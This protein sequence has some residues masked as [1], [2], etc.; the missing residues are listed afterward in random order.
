MIKKVLI[1]L[2]LVFIISCNST[3]VDYDNTTIKVGT[4][5]LE[6][7]GDGIDDRKQRSDY[8]YK[9]I[10]D[11]VKE[12]GADIIGLQEIENATALDKLIKHLPGFKYIVGETGYVQNPAVIFRDS[13]SVK[14]VENYQPLAVKPQ[15]TRAGL[16]V[17]VKKGN[18]DF[19]MMVVH[20]KSTSRYD[21]TEELRKESFE[22][23]RM[24]ALVVK[25]W[26][27][28]I[29]TKTKEKDVIVVGDF[30]DNP[31]RDTKVLIPLIQDN[32]Y[33]FLSDNLGSCKNPKWDC[34]D[35][36]VINRSVFERLIP[37]SVYMYDVP[38][39]YEDYEIE[40]ISD[41]CPV[42]TKFNILMPD[43]D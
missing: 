12:S 41:H 31:K 20:F 25:N 13:L 32:Q 2:S 18:F 6:W 37:G 24:Q 7:L 29:T 5:N 36:I 4:F 9:M 8:D 27:D 14:F 30:N 38:A 40:K 15:R 26:A 21:N 34:I 28:S 35:H 22:L 16:V 1:L 42:Y 17:E 3:K 11:L 23:R 43:N 39:K 33:M 10:A 19:V